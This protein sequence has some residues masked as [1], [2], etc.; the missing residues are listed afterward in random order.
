M[1]NLH[2]KDHGHVG[3]H[4]HVE[5]VIKEKSNLANFGKV[6]LTQ[7]FGSLRSAKKLT[8]LPYRGVACGVARRLPSIKYSQILIQIIN[9]N[10]LPNNPKKSK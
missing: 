4:H 1:P 8:E 3:A 2:F 9:K 5:G 7:Y 10:K 6:A